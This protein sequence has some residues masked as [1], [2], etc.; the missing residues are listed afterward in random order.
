M[1]RWITE[2]ELEDS[3]AITEDE[4]LAARAFC[5]QRTQENLPAFAAAFPGAASRDLYYQPGP[6]LG[7]TTGFWTGLVWLS[8]EAEE[9]PKR[10]AALLQAGKAQAA[11]F[12]RRIENREDVDHH[13]MGFLYTPSCVAAWR[14]LSDDDAK[15]AAILAANQLLARYQPVGQFLQAWGEMGAPENYRFI[16]DCLL[17]VPL[18]FWASSVTEDPKYR[19]VAL[20]HIHTALA[21]VIRED[22]STWHTVFMNPKTGEFDHGATCQGYRDGSAWARGQAWAVYGT[23]LAFRETKEETYLS[24]FRKVTS[25][26][27]S[28]LP[29]DLIPYWDLSF[30]DGDGYA[31]DPSIHGEAPF[32][33]SAGTNENG[34]IFQPRDASSAAIAVC[35]MLEMSRYLAQDEAASLVLTAKRLLKACTDTCLARPDTPTNGLLLH[36]TYSHRSPFNTCTPEGTEE[37]VIWGDYFLL[38]AL[39]R[40]TNPDWC[41]YW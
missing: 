1:K 41:V 40:V 10:K 39:T 32:E 5:V 37:C 34:G 6:N 36:S 25:Y 33:R 9:D 20:S 3:P 22:G 21:N 14:L 7:W 2:K 35:G 8:Y 4:A 15:L 24:A 30:G 16:V 26:F 28:H 38:E 27:L 19:E 13:D 12:L 17:N 11:D 18:L 31:L 29:K 23:A